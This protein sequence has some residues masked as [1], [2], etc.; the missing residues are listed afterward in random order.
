[1]RETE[2]QGSPHICKMLSNPLGVPTKAHKS[3]IESDAQKMRWEFPSVRQSFNPHFHTLSVVYLAPGEE[4]VDK[5]P[6]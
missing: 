4:E 5:D 1:M 6:L 3:P 2:P